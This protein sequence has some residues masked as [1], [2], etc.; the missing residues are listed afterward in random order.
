M[1]DVMEWLGDVF[2]VDQECVKTYEGY[3]SERI[4]TGTGYNYTTMQ[5]PFE[6]TVTTTTKALNYQAVAAFV[7]IVLVF[8]TVVTWLKGALRL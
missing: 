3:E 2:L 5:L 1:H 6:V 7:L 8:V 4:S